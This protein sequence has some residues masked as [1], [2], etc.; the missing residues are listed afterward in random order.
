[1][2]G[3]LVSAPCLTSGL[4]LAE[5]ATATQAGFKHCI[6]IFGRVK[7]KEFKI[8]GNFSSKILHKGI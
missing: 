8:K 7:K 5:V 3:F 6:N 4:R 2:T 1:M